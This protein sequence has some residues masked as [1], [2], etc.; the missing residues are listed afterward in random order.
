MVRLVFRPYTQIR[1]TICTSVSL[2]ASTRVS[3]GFT[4]PRHRSPSFGSQQICS[5]SNLSQANDRSIVP[6]CGFLPQ[7]ASRPLLS[8]RIRVWHPNTRIYVRLLGPCFKTGQL[9]PFRQHHDH[10]EPHRPVHHCQASRT[11]F[12][13]AIGSAGTDTDAK[14]AVSSSIKPRV[15]PHVGL[16]PFARLSPPSLIDADP[17]QATKT[18][19]GSNN[20]AQP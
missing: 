15:G 7:P 13:E 17:P 2:R 3:P 10:A 8:L 14:R 18:P 5:Y 11:L 20:E 16:G 4:L 9:K 12:S 19:T 6:P 1:R